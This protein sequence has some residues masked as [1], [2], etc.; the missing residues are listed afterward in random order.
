MT[1]FLLVCLQLK[2]RIDIFGILTKDHNVYLVGF[3]DWTGDTREIPDR[4]DA[5]V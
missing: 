2:A 3:P 5:G 1:G 4:P